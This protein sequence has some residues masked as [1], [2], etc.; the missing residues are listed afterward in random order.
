MVPGAAV[1][2]VV[3][4]N[5]V[6]LQVIGEFAHLSLIFDELDEAVAWRWHKVGGIDLA[7]G[8]SKPE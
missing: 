1:I 3:N 6:H 4:V 7:M 5:D 8:M 2:I